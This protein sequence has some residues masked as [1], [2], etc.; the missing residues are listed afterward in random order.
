MV[1]HLAKQIVNVSNMELARYLLTLLKYDIWEKKT[2]LWI[3]DT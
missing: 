3:K 2:A 1:K